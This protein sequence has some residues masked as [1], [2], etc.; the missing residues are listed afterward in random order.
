MWCADRP[1]ILL[2][3][4]GAG[5]GGREE[6]EE[7]GEAWLMCEATMTFLDDFFGGSGS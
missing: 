1:H 4:P 2:W 5:G 6:E 7:V 3:V